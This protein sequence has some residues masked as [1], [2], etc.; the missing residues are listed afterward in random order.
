MYR[1]RGA[2]S[3]FATGRNAARIDT[4]VSSVPVSVKKFSSAVRAHWGF[5]NSFDWV[6]EMTFNEDQSRIRQGHSQ[7]NFAL[8]RRFAIIIL[9]LDTS[10][11]STRKKRKRSAWDEN[12]LQNCLAAIIQD[13]VALAANIGML[14]FL[15]ISFSK[16]LRIECTHSIALL[17]VETLR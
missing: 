6:L 11:E 7:E 17:I 4:I 10:K 5:E 1:N 8:L 12:Y 14:I 3:P 16:N 15:T 2:T 9:S 13:A